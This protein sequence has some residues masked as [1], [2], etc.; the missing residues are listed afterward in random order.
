ML[1]WWF[2]T[3]S[4]VDYNDNDDDG[5]TAIAIVDSACRP[6][7]MMKYFFHWLLVV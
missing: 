1:V 2:L 4:V 7:E 3:E 6:I 5:E